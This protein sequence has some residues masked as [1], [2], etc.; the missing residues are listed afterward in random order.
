MPG[1]EDFG[2]RQIPGYR[3]LR[4]IGRGGMGVTY[5]A[6]Q[7]SLGRRVV[8]K[9]LRTQSGLDPF[10]QAARFRREAE[11]MAS[12]SHPNVVT[13]FE[14]GI[15][16][17]R[18]FLVMEYIEGGDLRARMVPGEPLPIGRVR[19]L[20]GPLVRALE[21]LHRIGILHRDLKP[22]N[23]LMSHEDAPKVSDFGI[24]VPQSDV[25]ALTRDDRTLGTV[26][27]AAP[28]QQYRLRVDERS[29]QYSLAAVVYEM[30]TGQ[31]PLGSFPPPSRLNRRVPPAADA[32]IQRAL[33]EDRDDR[34]AS[35]VAFGDA[36]DRALAAPAPSGRRRVLW[37]V[38]AVVLLALLGIRGAQRRGQVVALVDPAPKVEVSPKPEIPA[39]KVE[40]PAPKAEGQ[41]K[42]E[43]RASKDE[44]PPR[45]DPP[46]PEDRRDDRA[47]PLAARAAPKPAVPPARAAKKVVNSLGMILIKVPA[48]EFL[49]GSPDSDPTAGAEEKPQHVV[50]LTRPFYLGAHEVTVGQFRAFVEAT[51]YKT[52]AEQDGKGG[53]IF[54]NKRK[55]AV[56][57]PGLNWRR[58]GF[59]RDQA[60]DEPVVQVSWHDAIAFCEWLTE[61]EEIVYRLPSEAE[62]EYACR[63]GSSGRWCFGDDPAPLGDYAWTRDNAGYITHAVGTKRPNAFGLFD[64]HGNV[65]EWCQDRY[66]AAYP[67]GPEENPKGPSEGNQRVVHGGSWDFPEVERTRSAERQPHAS[68]FSYYTIGFR[69]RRA[70]APPAHPPKAP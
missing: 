58:P 1:D 13:V 14:F 65:W 8:V 3:L 15:D 27:Y 7:L 51:N 38:A 5:L 50:R 19:A 17:G 62:W 69:V 18:P 61:R 31:L 49:M 36:L 37:A 53:A 24:A 59:W 40:I 30:L 2:L 21:Y 16:D 29:D 42:D 67:P 6:E 57:D 70:I 63:A 26:G 43:A 25:G 68:N 45:A 9:Y 46:A 55:K 52:R 39:P 12:A 41:A 32:V 66:A 34:Y 4:P 47:P 10:E 64:M 11:L 20:V 33:S 23:I 48:G 44:T 54:D 22:E 60:D 56:K 35:I 28:E